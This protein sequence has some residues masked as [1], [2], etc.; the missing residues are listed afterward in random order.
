MFRASQALGAVA[1]VLALG[2]IAGCGGGS[3]LEALKDPGVQGV[4]A[5]RQQLRTALLHHD[6]K[7]QCELF[8][9][10]VIENHGGSLDACAKSLREGPYMQSPSAFVAGGHIELNGNQARYMI[11]F[12]QVPSEEPTEFESEEPQVAFAATYTEGSWRIVERNE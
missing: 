9:P 3:S 2:A 12:G 10:I 4:E 11:P 7:T 5:L 6:Q 8:A 1:L